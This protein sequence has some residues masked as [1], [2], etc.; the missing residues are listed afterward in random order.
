MKAGRCLI[1]DVEESFFDDRTVL[2]DFGKHCATKENGVGR[3]L[4][5]AFRGARR[6]RRHHQDAQR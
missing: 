3:D 4:T 6:V 1:V 2:A 5:V